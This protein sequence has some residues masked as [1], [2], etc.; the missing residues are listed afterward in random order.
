MEQRIEALEQAVREL[1]EADKAVKAASDGPWPELWMSQEERD[2]IDQP[3]L[4]AMDRFNAAYATLLLIAA[5]L[6]P[7]VY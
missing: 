2:E 4:E 3:L 7:R 5:M 1:Y 6:P